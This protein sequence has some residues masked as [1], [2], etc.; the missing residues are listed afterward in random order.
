MRYF[1][2]LLIPVFL[3]MGGIS[4]IAQDEANALDYLPPSQFISGWVASGNEV[5]DHPDDLEWLLGDGLQLLLEYEPVWFATETYNRIDDE[6]VVELYQF[7]TSGDAFGFYSLSNAAF[8]EFVPDPYE[9]EK[10]YDPPPASQL[11][12]VRIISKEFVEG[13]QDK[14]YF[15]IRTKEEELYDSGTRAALY[16]QMHLP[17]TSVPAAITGILPADGL[18][19]GSERYVRGAAGLDYLAEWNAYDFLGF[20]EYDWKAVA[21]EYR[22]SGGKVFLLIIGEYEDDDTARIAGD[23]LQDYFQDSDWETV[24][25][26]SPDDSIHP[27]AF[28]GLTYAAFWVKDNHLWLL[29]DLDTPTD[30]NNAIADYVM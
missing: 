3:S 29:W 9:V 5:F 25:V 13:Y 10:P 2:F 11:G 12:T 8:K 28:L 4:T 21:G 16:L 23:R 18:V 1:F 7:Q 26:G 22:V 19:G 15:R 24:I 20:D 27:R 17:G 14:F 6:M 30:L